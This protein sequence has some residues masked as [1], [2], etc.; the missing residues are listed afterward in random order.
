MSSFRNKRVL[1]TGGCGFVGVNLLKKLLKEGAIIRSTVYNKKPL[2]AKKE[3]EYLKGDL[4]EDKFCD[5]VVENIDYVFHCAAVSAG[6]EMMQKNPLFLLNPNIFMSLNL[7]KSAQKSNVKKFIF[8]SSST[9]YPLTDYAVKEED[10]STEFFE[11]YF[12]SGWMKKF[13]EATCEMYS[14][15]IN[16]PLV[17]IIVRPSNLYG[18]YDKFDKKR[19]KVIPALIRRSLDKESPFVVWGDGND[20]KDFIY[21]DDFIDGL[22]NAAKKLTSFNVVNLGFGEPVTIK[23]ILHEVLE[24][25]NFKNPELFFDT[26]KPTMIPKRIVDISKAKRLINFKPKYD[27]KNGIKETVKW[28]N[29]FFINKNPDDFIS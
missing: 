21:I 8:I 23:Q 27:I 20:L 5:K 28:Y 16:K 2:V 11:K 12:I 15:K 26:S 14:T 22:I 17:T 19:S 25:T 18:P 13:L 9:V 6:A 29:S 3:I 7:I 1:V 4:L 10:S 24:S